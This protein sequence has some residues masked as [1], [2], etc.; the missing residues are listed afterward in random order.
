MCRLRTDTRDHIDETT[1]VLTEYNN[2]EYLWDA[3]FAVDYAAAGVEARIGA[4]RVAYTFSEMLTQPGGRHQVEVCR[5][6]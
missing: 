6:W 2:L 3:G 1:R 4:W 5:P